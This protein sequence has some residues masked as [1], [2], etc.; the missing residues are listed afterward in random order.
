MQDRIASR[1]ALA[2]LLLMLTIAGIGAAGP[3]LAVH[4]PP[5]GVIIVTGGALEIVLAGLLVA[6]RW[7][8]PPAEGV[9][10]RLRPLLSRV[11][12][13]GLF[14]IPAAALIAGLGRI[15][16]RRRSRARVLP[17]GGRLGR[18]HLA[19][20]GPHAG[21]LALGHDVLIAALI[22]ALL[23]AAFLIWR[24]RRSLARR[25][26]RDDLADDETAAPADPARAASA[27]DSGRQAMRE[28]DDARAA[29]I[30]CYRAMEE[31]LAGAGAVRGVAETPHEL[32]ARVGGVGTV[33]SMVSAAPAASLTA[34]FYEARF[35]THPMPASRRDAAVRALDELA[36]SLPAPAAVGEG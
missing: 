33:V 9:T 12:A 4:R 28:L 18:P 7:R 17:P 25:G 30:A 1:T 22:A 15:R 20:P 5:S 35:S 23:L 31:S 16:W 21:G 2:V 32:L 29:I 26:R 34:L 14:A 6:L 10:G 8:A 27:I 3:A 19:R 11:L 24:R 13:T 36:A